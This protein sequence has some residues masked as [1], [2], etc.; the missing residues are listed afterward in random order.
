MSKIQLP[1]EYKDRG[2]GLVLGVYLID[3]K[4]MIYSADVTPNIIEAGGPDYS[5]FSN[6]ADVW[7]RSQPRHGIS[8]TPLEIIIAR[9]FPQGRVFFERFEYVG[10]YMVRLIPPVV[11]NTVRSG[12]YGQA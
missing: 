9:N 10:A 7:V 5:K 12:V 1:A 4:I 8:P 6:I 11:S 2:Y 3:L